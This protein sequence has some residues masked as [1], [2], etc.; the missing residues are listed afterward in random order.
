MSLAPIDSSTR[1]SLRSGWRRFAAVTASR[2]SV[3]CALTLPEQLAPDLVGG[4]SR[5]LLRAEQPVGDGGAGAGQRQIGHRDVR[6]LHGERQRG[7]GLVAVQR[8]MAGRIEPQRALALPHLQ[9]V[10]RFAGPAALIAGAARAV[11][12]RV[13]HSEIG[14]ETKPLVRQR[15]RPVRIAFARRDAVAETGDEDIAHRDLGSDPLRR[16][17]AG[18]DVDGGDRGPAVA[19]AEIDRLGAIEGG[20]P[21]TVAIVEG[22]G[23]GGADRDL[24]GQP[25]GDRV[26]R[27]CQVAFLDAVADAGL[28][29]A[30]Q[31]IDAQP[32]HRIAGPAAAVALQRQR[33]LR[34]EN[35]AAAA[36]I[37]MEQEVAL[38]AEQ[39]EAVADL[40]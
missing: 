4:H 9:A 10:G 19:R 21:R 36:A 12:L 37:G 14:A 13:G 28:A 7:A 26:V 6:I 11:I 25:H 38:L 22:P 1:S 39:P 32:V 33:L 29:D 2:N 20:L 27:R 40:P 34:G 23:A 31:Q 8:A 30:A 5:A 16:F 35:A 15:D 3:S 18:R 17:G 24:S